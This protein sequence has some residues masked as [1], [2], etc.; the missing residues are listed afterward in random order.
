MD[1]V[2]SPVPF[3]AASQRTLLGRLDSVVLASFLLH[4][5]EEASHTKCEMLLSLESRIFSLPYSVG[6]RC[7]VAPLDLS[8]RCPVE[9]P[10]CPVDL[11][12]LLPCCR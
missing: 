9:C 4:L 1:S 2:F 6:H 11:L 8:G 12:M 3:F 5:L 7:P 10:H